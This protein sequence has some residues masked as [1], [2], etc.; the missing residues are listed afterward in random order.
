MIAKENNGD[1]NEEPNISYF[2]T[3][4]KEENFLFHKGETQFHS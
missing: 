1:Y 2:S 3:E 4:F